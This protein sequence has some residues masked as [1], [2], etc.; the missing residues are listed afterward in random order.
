MLDAP[1]LRPKHVLDR[2]DIAMRGEWKAVAVG[3]RS[4][5][6]I[7]LTR[8]RCANLDI[9]RAELRQR[10]HHAAGIKGFRDWDPKPIDRLDRPAVSHTLHTCRALEH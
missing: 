1:L 6:V 3:G 7:G 8:Y 2:D 9:I 4:D 5:G 10:I